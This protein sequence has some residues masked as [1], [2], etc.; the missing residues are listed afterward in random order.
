MNLTNR[1][2]QM[3]Q[4]SAPKRHVTIIGAGVVG[5]SSA[6]RLQRAGC[7]V[8]VVDR[9]SPG[10]S[11]SR[12]NAGIFA[13][14]GMV[15]LSTPGFIWKVPG[16]LTDPLGPL[17]MRWRHVP[18]MMPWMVKFLR[19]SRPAEVERIAAALASLTRTT[20]DAHMALVAGTGA[21][22]LARAAPLLCVYPDEASYQND[23][24]VWNL[25]RQHGTRM[26]F[27][28]DDA[29]RDFEPTVSE[30][31]KFGVV[32]E[33]CGYSP[34]PFELV[35]TLAAH[36]VRSGGNI[37][38]R[39]VRDIVVGPN[40]P[41]ALV[42]DAG[43]LP[44]R[45]LVI[46]GGAWSGKLSRKLGSPVPLEAE[47][48]YHVTLQRH[49]GQAPRY[50]V[51]SPAQKILVTPM[52][53]GLRAA[54]LVEFDGLKAA[55]DYRRA[56]TLLKHINALFPAVEVQAHTE[57]MGHRPSLPD[58]LPV[59]DRSPHFT[60]VFYGFGHQHIGLTCA[61]KTAEAL[62]DLVLQRTPSIDLTP[63]RISRF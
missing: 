52:Q 7:D 26:H 62:T 3:S 8:T 55:P 40:G 17:A 21:E 9:V 61:P 59:I 45:E 35:K 27:L 23:I 11:C 41:I 15:P 53:C 58:S 19:S 50:P 32:M 57:W 30:R 6:I 1:I 47:R 37:L 18:S 2:F 51:M 10:E 25:R 34:D 36:F 14:Y 33:N 28:R 39:D 63:F 16:M 22:P 31:F 54:G 5:I 43:N 24:Y 13:T 60:N 42:T 20:V 4:Q 12:G 29:V 44:V 46:C 48:G 38:T 56:R 49:T